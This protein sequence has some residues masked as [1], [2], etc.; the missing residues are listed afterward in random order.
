MV[1]NKWIETLPAWCEFYIFNKYLML[2]FTFLGHNSK[3]SNLQAQFNSIMISFM[4][5]CI[6]ISI[7]FWP[8]NETFSSLGW[9]CARKWCIMYGEMKTFLMFARTE[10]NNFSVIWQD[11][12][13]HLVFFLWWWCGRWT[14]LKIK[15]STG[16]K[17][18]LLSLTKIQYPD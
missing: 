10:R 1:W 7:A 4:E 16:K 2:V 18:S 12:Q 11:C 14:I 9:K 15:G 8:E 17:Y 13:N 3:M 5:E 6:I